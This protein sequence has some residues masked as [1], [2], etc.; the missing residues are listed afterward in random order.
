VNINQDA[1]AYG[2]FHLAYAVLDG[3]VRH[4]LF[5]LRKSRDSTV[6]PE[7]FQRGNFGKRLKKLKAE[8]EL[9]RTDMSDKGRFEKLNVNDE[10]AR[11]DAACAL[12]G[13]VAQW[14]NDRIH[15]AQIRIMETQHVFV[16]CDKNG[17]PMPIDYDECETKIREAIH[18]N[19]ELEA[20]V[21]LIVR[22]RDWSD[23]N[24]AEIF[25]SEPDDDVE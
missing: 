13:K 16:L 8:L 1:A 18:A 11:L 6:T 12:A 25:P 14:R 2:L 17:S 5:L 7:Q 10:L 22:K 19:V 9:L 24:Y 3:R 20:N 21:N 15:P 4:S 23:R